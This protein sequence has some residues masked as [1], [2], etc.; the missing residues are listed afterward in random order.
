M[1][2]E[3]IF[4][5]SSFK[6][7]VVVPYLNHLDETVQMRGH[8]IWFYAELTNIIPNYHQIPPFSRA[9]LLVVTLHSILQL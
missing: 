7:Y 8:N 2:I 5:Y 4:S 6:P 1:I 9:L 3:D